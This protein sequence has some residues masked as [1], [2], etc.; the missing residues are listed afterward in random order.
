MIPMEFEPGRRCITSLGWRDPRT[1]EGELMFPKRFPRATVSAL[2]IS[3]GEYGT[4]GQL[5]QRPSPDGGGILQPKHFQ[6]WPV[7]KPLPQI[8]HVV[9]SYDTAYTEDTANDPCACTVWGIFGIVDPDTQ[10][11]KRCAMLMD[12][13]AEHLSYP[14]LKP[15]LI[16]DWNSKYGGDRNDPLNKPRRPD[17]MI[18]EEKG[19]GISLIQDLRA[20]NLPVIPYNPGR[21][22][23]ITRAHL[24]APLLETDCFFILESSREKGKF[25]MWARDFCE[26]LEQFPNGEH[27]DFV[28]TFTQAALYL[29]R[30][31]HLLMEKVPRDVIEEKDYEAEKK[32]K[33]NPYNV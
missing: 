28:D 15:K 1:D 3:L 19:S 10:E 30:S 17:S 31:E 18:I 6:I 24:V 12:A 33:V 11:L 27:D 25:V 7:N 21:A 5:Q 16:K 14:K 26:Q 20:A 8:A 4:A 2:K 23:K 32:R 13:W 29:Q 9:Q 22:S